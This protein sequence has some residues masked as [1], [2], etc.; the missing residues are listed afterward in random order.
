MLISFLKVFLSIYWTNPTNSFQSQRK[1]NCQSAKAENGKVDFPIFTS[2]QENCI[3]KE[4]AKFT[5]I[6]LFVYLFI[7]LS[8]ERRKS[9]DLF[10]ELCWTLKNSPPFWRNAKNGKKAKRME[11]LDIGSRIFFRNSCDS[12]T[13]S[14]MLV[15]IFLTF[16]G[17]Y[18][19]SIYLL[20]EICKIGNR[21]GKISE[22]MKNFPN[23]M[24]RSKNL[25]FTLKSIR[26][27]VPFYWFF[28]YLERRI[29]F[30]DLQANKWSFLDA[31]VN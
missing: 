20:T 5:P 4:R 16:P 26:K 21:R 15:L 11:I 3:F 9:E 1:K 14:A 23:W 19:S 24:S 31:L 8:R 12:L 27:K 17:F 22:G 6:Y 28:N 13:F 10:S 30:F 25:K 2:K 18:C 7:Y 29:N